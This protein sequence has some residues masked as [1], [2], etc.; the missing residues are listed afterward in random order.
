MV[1]LAG[2]AA[3]ASA[4][5]N[6]V[7]KVA[8]IQAVSYFAE[9]AQ[10]RDLLENL[11]RQAAAAGAKVVVVPETAISG[12]MDHQLKKTW[13]IGNR[14][15]TSGLRGVSPADV[16]ETVPGP[17]TQ[18]WA[19]LAAELK[20]YLTAPFVEID[21]STGNYYNTV[22]L[23]GPTGDHLLHYRKLHPWPW[24]ESGWATPG[25]HGNVFVDTHYGRMSLLIC[26]D[27]NFE[28]ENLK[29]LGVD[30]LLYPV[31][32]VDHEESDWFS[33][34]LPEIA[35]RN[36]LNIIGAN[37]TVP[38]GSRPKWHGFG[39]TRIIDCRGRILAEAQNAIG[40]EIVYA[41]LPIPRQPRPQQDQETSNQAPSK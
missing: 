32:W 35:A 8:A 5:P 15:L 18:A 28:P 7:F 30:H 22:V 24:A 38:P 36:H 2:Y 20:I 1:S 6:A 9:P 19:K 10:N 13:R 12:Y 4:E 27:I 16:A 23:L 26:Y 25:D 39:R 17:S 29:E 3:W 11:I 33:V 21:R 31:A 34:R 37:W 40:P 14:K 41:D